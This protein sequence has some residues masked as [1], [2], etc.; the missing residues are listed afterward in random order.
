MTLFNITKVDETHALTDPA[1]LNIARYWTI[2]LFNPAE[3]TYCAELTASYWLEAVGYDIEPVDSDLDPWIDDDL[4]DDL[5]SDLSYSSHYRHIRATPDSQPFGEFETLE[6]A[7]EHYHA[8]PW[9]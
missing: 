3:A 9:Y 4:H 7:V 6:D 1:S 8:N 5:M 2:Y